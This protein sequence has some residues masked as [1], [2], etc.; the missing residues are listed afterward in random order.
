MEVQGELN[1]LAKTSGFAEQYA[2][3]IWAGL[4]PELGLGLQFILN[5]IAGT[6]GLASQGAANVIAGTNGLG[7][8][9]ALASIP[10]PP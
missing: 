9:A 3:A 4:D 7:L 1:R 6:D 8:P 10:T 5:Y 2:A